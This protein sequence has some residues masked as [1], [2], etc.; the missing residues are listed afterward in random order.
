[1]TMEGPAMF[2]KGNH[3][4]SDCGLEAWLPEELGRELYLAKLAEAAARVPPEGEDFPEDD[5]VPCSD[6]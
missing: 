4:V 6:D 2:G 1:M 5:E 3:K